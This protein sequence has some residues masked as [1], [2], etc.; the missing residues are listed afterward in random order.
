MKVN[1]TK[2]TRRQRVASTC[3]PRDSRQFN[4]ISTS[5]AC[6]CNTLLYLLYNCQCAS[7]CWEAG[8]FLS[9]ST[10]WHLIAISPG[11][12][13][14]SGLNNAYGVV[15]KLSMFAIKQVPLPHSIDVHSTSRCIGMVFF[16]CFFVILFTYDWFNLIATVLL[17]DNV[18]LIVI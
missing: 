16:C 8:R 13:W 17:A 15:H 3:C 4:V 11:L 2:H 9:K 18:I 1:P 14:P 5:C 6:W 7:N 10:V 12:G